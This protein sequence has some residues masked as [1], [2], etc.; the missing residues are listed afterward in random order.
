MVDLVCEL[1][2]DKSFLAEGPS[3]ANA[4]AFCFQEFHLLYDVGEVLIVLSIVV[5]ISKEAPLIKVIDSILKD[6]ILG[7]ISPEVAAVT[8]QLERGQENC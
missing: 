6:G 5:D 1:C 3:L 8:E 4:L 7:P 2:R